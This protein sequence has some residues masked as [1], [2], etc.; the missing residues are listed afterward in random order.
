MRIITKDGHRL[1]GVDDQVRNRIALIS[2]YGVVIN[3]HDSTRNSMGLSVDPIKPFELIIDTGMMLID[4]I[5]VEEP[6]VQY[7]DCS[8]S[9]IGEYFVVAYQNFNS[10]EWNY[11]LETSVPEEIDLVINP[12]ETAGVCLGKL[13]MTISGLSNIISTKSSNLGVPYVKPIQEIEEIMNNNLDAFKE[14]IIAE[15]ST[16]VPDAKMRC[17]QGLNRIIEGNWSEDL[18][19]DL[20]AS[21]SSYNHKYTAGKVW[22]MGFL[23]DFPAGTATMAE[24]SETTPNYCVIYYVKV[25]REK[26]K[27]P[28]ASIV[29]LPMVENLQGTGMLQ[30]VW[31]TDEWYGT[32]YI[33][34]AEG[35][36]SLTTGYA[37]NRIITTFIK[38]ATNSPVGDPWLGTQL[39]LGNKNKS[40]VKNYPW[41]DTYEAS[42][43]LLLGADDTVTIIGEWATISTLLSSA[44][45][46]GVRMPRTLMPNT[47][48][49]GTYFVCAGNGY[50]TWTLQIE[51]TGYIYASKY[52]PN[53]VPT[54]GSG[55]WLPF[56]VTFKPATLDG[57][58]YYENPENI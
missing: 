17:Q 34:I 45:I 3:P 49:A 24:G 27:E 40:Q 50:N 31:Y 2:K 51:N 13:E 58:V 22:I 1:T 47:A 23:F 19:F 14:E 25:V 6:E 32:A 15:V 10:G 4:G 8:H 43:F 35:V 56:T 55:A 57:N 28:T 29:Y 54:T 20:E 53:A 5:Q 38:P 52:G 33:P 41:T 37:T 48:L 44:K 36:T 12:D 11:L 18:R 42:A 39:L 21:I 9:G 26:G 7:I 46:Y 30:G 16:V